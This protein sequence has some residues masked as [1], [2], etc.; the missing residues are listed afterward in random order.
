LAFDCRA[1]Q[2]LEDYRLLMQQPDDDKLDV[3]LAATLIARH[4]YPTLQHDTIVE[5][6]DD[7]AVQVSQQRCSSFLP[8]CGFAAAWNV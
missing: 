1:Q 8:V 5:Q 4:R 3:L 2:A 6:L 7:L